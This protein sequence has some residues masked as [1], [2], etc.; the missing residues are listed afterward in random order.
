L[1]NKN[2]AK[3]IWKHIK[4]ASNEVN[5]SSILPST[6]TID[7]FNVTGKQNVANAITIY[8]V[9]ISK[10]VNMFHFNE[11]Y[12]NDLKTFLNNKLGDN[13]FR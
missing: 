8:F 5:K 10:C 7:N 6:I 9:N 3:Y 12:F 2:E 4:S 1:Q 13:G 11:T